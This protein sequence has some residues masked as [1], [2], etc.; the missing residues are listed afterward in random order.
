MTK[1]VCTVGKPPEGEQAI[2]GAN[3]GGDFCVVVVPELCGYDVRFFSRVLVK[4][5]GEINSRGNAG[6]CVW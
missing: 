1:G 2:D 4:D 6:V 5:L 3:V